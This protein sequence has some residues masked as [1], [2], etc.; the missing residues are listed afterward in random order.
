MTMTN[1]LQHP[2]DINPQS[3]DDE[4]TSTTAQSSHWTDKDS[5]VYLAHDEKIHN[6]PGQKKREHMIEYLAKTLKRMKDGCGVGSKQLKVSGEWVWGLWERDWGWERSIMLQQVENTQ[7]KRDVQLF[8]KGRVL[9][10][11][12]IYHL[13]NHNSYNVTNLFL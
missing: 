5:S 12:Q 7:Q 13:Q 8:E 4:R 10:C 6:Y 1:V 2:N 9:N 3:K 11:N